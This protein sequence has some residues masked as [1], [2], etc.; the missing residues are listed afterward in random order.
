MSWREHIE[1]NPAVLVGKPIVKGTR[2][3]V[4][5]VV[6]MLANGVS[7]SELLASYPTLTTESIRACLAYAADAL[8][9]ERIYPLSA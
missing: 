8:K 4:E 7:E 2:I 1:V 3:A 6:E 9:S 5:Q